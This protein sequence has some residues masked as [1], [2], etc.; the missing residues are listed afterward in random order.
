MTRIWKRNAMRLHIVCSLIYWHEG[1]KTQVAGNQACH[2]TGQ[3]KEL[4]SAVCLVA[5]QSLIGML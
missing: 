5:Q 4:K 2:L 1:A 3:E